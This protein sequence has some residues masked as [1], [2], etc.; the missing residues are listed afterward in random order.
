M[1]C[2]EVTGINILYK[3]HLMN[4]FLHNHVDFHTYRLGSSLDPVISDL[5]D[6]LES[7]EP[8]SFVGTSDYQGILTR[9]VIAANKENKKTRTLWLWE[10]ADWEGI[11]R[12]L[13]N[14]D[15]TAVIY[16]DINQQ[17][18]QLTTILLEL[19][20]TYVPQR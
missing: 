12:A 15:W 16:G 6:L 1:S 3:I 5:R 11:T 18:T 20:N 2:Y 19:Q 10:K 14:I 8:L 9:F 7:C 17:V 13:R 4:F